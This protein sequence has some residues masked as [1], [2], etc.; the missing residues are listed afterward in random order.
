[1][2]ATE[3]LGTFHI[4][5]NKIPNEDKLIKISKVLVLGLNS[6]YV[7]IIII[8]GQSEVNVPTSFNPLHPY[9]SYK[10]KQI[11]T[12]LR[13]LQSQQK[14]K[15]GNRSSRYRIKMV[16]GIT[17]LRCYDILENRINKKLKNNSKL[18]VFNRF[19][20]TKVQQFTNVSSALLKV[21]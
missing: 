1:M 9:L 15:K 21:T 10:L 17:G 12:D 3:Q 19:I 20:Y 16:D 8:I 18:V 5:M 14:T 13:V 7:Q 2:Q 6:S 11:P 4:T